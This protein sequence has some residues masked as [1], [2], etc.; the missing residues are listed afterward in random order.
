MQKLIHAMMQRMLQRVEKEV[1]ETG[2]FEIVEVGFDNPDPQL[3]VRRIWLEVAQPPEGIDGR[4]CKRCL[5]IVADNRE[6]AAVEI[7]LEN[8]TKRTIIEALQSD[9]LEERLLSSIKKLDYHLRG[10]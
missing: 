6:G 10:L 2:D 8:G 3:G 4:Q 7:M 5:K 9:K 1:P